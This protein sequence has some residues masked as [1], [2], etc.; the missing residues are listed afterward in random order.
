[1]VSIDLIF[2]FEAICIWN[3]L[4]WQLK[5][6]S[7]FQWNSESEMDQGGSQ[8]HLNCYE[9]VLFLLKVFSRYSGQF[10]YSNIWSCRF[11]DIFE[12]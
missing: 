11:L 2:G 12:Y 1:M 6:A 7:N 10:S 5:F 3:L 9:M 4:D 8:H